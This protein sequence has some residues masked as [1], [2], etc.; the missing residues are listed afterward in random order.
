[1]IAVFTQTEREFQ[2][3]FKFSPSKGFIRIRNVEDVSG[4][5]FD[6]VIE[7]TGWHSAFDKDRNIIEAYDTLRKRQP[8]LFI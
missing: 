8:E 1:M 4:R 7:Y 6:G 5:I 2:R 3:N